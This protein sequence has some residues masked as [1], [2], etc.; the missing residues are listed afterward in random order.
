GHG[1][2][3][4]PFISG[5]R[6]PGWHAEARAVIAGLQTH[7]SPADILRASMEALAY[8]LQA[9]YQ[10]LSG[11]LDVHEKKPRLVGSGGALLSSPTLQHIVADALGTPLYPLQE[12]EASARGV[13]LLAL[14]VMGMIQ[15]VGQVPP[16]LADPVKPDAER[17]KIYQKAAQRQMQ[18]YR[19]LL[20]DL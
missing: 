17:G 4:L 12:H 7:T 14:E 1:L 6:S 3:I 5:E 13:A 20:G 9:V 16:S 8:Q 19:V 11:A 18:L 15:D 10:Q 2:T